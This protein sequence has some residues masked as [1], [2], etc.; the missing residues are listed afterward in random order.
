MQNAEN[1]WIRKAQHER[2]ANEI[3]QLSNGRQIAA[4]SRLQQFD[5]FI[6]EH[7]LLKIGGRLQN[8]DLPENMKHPILLPDNPF[9]P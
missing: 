1:H 3:R 9:R 8:S 5:P 6:D 2:F 7:G 4:N